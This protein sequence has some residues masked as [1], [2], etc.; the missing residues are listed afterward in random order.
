MFLSHIK[1]GTGRKWTG[2]NQLVILGFDKF[3]FKFPSFHKM[4]DLVVD[5]STQKLGWAGEVR[6]VSVCCR[7]QENEEL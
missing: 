3:L 4:L 2:E 1:T 6:L 5:R 7:Q